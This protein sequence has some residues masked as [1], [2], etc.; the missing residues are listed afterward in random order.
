MKSKKNIK[1]V[2][3]K[4][5]PTPE[6]EKPVPTPKS[7]PVAEPPAKP[8]PAKTIKAKPVANQMPDLGARV[9]EL[10][11]DMVRLAELLAGVLGEP[12]ASHA[13]DIVIKKQG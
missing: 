5:A 4:P 7:E 1:P 9:K 2:K 11:G 12:F 3:S 6:I 13:K 8:E 10:E